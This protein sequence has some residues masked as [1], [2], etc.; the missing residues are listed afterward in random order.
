MK[1]ILLSIITLII[2]LSSF[3]QHEPDADEIQN[4]GKFLWGIGVGNSYQQADRNALDN[5]ITQIS[6][7]VE[8]SFENFLSETDGNLE[9]YTKSVV[10]TYS[11]VTLVSAKSMLID[12]KR[13]MYEVM[14]YMA[15]DDLNII[16][17]NRK[18]KIFDYVK[19]GLIAEKKLR[20][21]DALKNYYWAMV[22]L[23]SHKDN[24][25]L[26]CDFPEQGKRLLITAL[27]DRI[28]A[29][30]T[31]LRFFIKEI[32]DIP[33]EQYK[34]IHLNITYQDKP[35]ENLDY[36]YWTGRNY[37]NLVS[38]RSGLGIIELF[39]DVE[40]QVSELKLI[41]EYAYTQKIG[42]DNE[43]RTVF[44]NV[45]LPYFGRA[46]FICFVMLHYSEVGVDAA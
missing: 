7:Q 21:G 45:N 39:G 1:K 41:V 32:E 5:L 17:E 31:S 23:R 40:Y 8:S 38:C 24:D 37:S 19:S 11:N 3:T 22:L 9:E 34:A 44:D 27:P 26:Q 42:M 29:L 36:V 25:N 43:V 10:K 14:R 46:E 13:G 20:I 15:K 16:F 18:L 30:F 28:N 2:S 12:E 33:A 4:S 6:V 35:V